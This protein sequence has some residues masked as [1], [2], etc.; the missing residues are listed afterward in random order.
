MKPRDYLAGGQRALIRFAAGHCTLGEI[1]VAATDVGICAILLGDDAEALVRDLQDRF[2]KAEL[3]GGDAGF[4]SLVGQVIAHVDRP[5]G[6][7]ELPLDIRGTAFQQRVWQALQTIPA[8]STASYSEVARQPRRARRRAR[9]GRRL[10]GERHRSRDPVSPRRPAGR[11]LVGLSL[12][13]GAQARA[14]A[15]GVGALSPLRASLDA[16]GHAI[17]GHLLSG[18][19]CAD[20][21]ALYDAPLE[22]GE[23]PRFRSRIAMERYNFGRGEYQYFAYPLPEPVSELRR[24]LYA[25]LQPIANE[26]NELMGIDIR[27]PPEHDEFMER[28]RAAGQTRPTPLML[29]YLPGDYNCLHQDLYGEH[30]FPLQAT[31]LLSAPGRDFEGG[32][33]VMT[34]QRPR[35]QSRPI[36]VPLERGDAVVLPVH[37]RPVQGGRGTYRVNMRHGVSELRSGQ[38]HTLGIIFHDAPVISSPTSICRRCRTSGSKT[39]PS[40]LE[41]S[42]CRSPKYLLPTSI[43][44]PCRRRCDT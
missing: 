35:M 38:R 44:W 23:P 43:A 22:P 26:W 36:V 8:G 39:A 16:K 18:A 14:A 12:G 1:V 28:C 41:A 5:T 34:E 7:F 27:Y 42:R 6:N 17:L 32:E 9:S 21:V 37:H 3:V 2:P 31:V 24:S 25:Q 4:E 13:R 11:R 19:Q 10:R 15:Q 20:M 33:F 29:K 30:V 40:S